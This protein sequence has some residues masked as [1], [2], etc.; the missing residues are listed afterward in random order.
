MGSKWPQHWH[1]ASAYTRRMLSVSVLAPSALDAVSS[2]LEEPTF[3][4]PRRAPVPAPA[5]P[6][7]CEEAAGSF[8]TVIPTVLVM[9]VE[10]CVQQVPCQLYIIL[11]YSVS[12]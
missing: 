6:H 7:T 5:E 8:L 3:S 12:P 9:M 1:T 11:E 10:L 2:S 4:V